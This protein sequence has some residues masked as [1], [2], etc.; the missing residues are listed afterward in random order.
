M[1]KRRRKNKQ[2]RFRFFICLLIALFVIVYAAPVVRDYRGRVGGDM[3]KVEIV[4]G[5]GTADVAQALQ[6]QG[7]IKNT[8]W[9]R[10]FSKICGYDGRYQQGTFSVRQHA[11]YRAAFEA[12]QHADS[13]AVRVTIPEGYELRQIADKL[14]AAGLIDRNKFY[15]AV[16]KGDF[17]Y[18][19]LAGL[20][21]RENR[22]E[23]Y[24]FPD[25]Y[26]FQQGDSEENII[27]IMLQ[28]FNE[29]Y[30]E[31]YRKRAKELSMTDDQV[32]TLASV[33]ER[34]AMGDAD[35]ALVAGVFHNRL[36][37]AQYPY[38]ESCATVQYILKERKAVLS[39]KDTGIDSPYNT[40]R[41]PG[42]PIGPI[43]SPGQASIQAALYPAKTDYLFFVLDSSGTHRFAKTF[44]EHQQ[45]MAK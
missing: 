22:L 23:G 30:T 18:W 21:K 41:Y 28:R 40:Y 1:R 37:N 31:T 8:F 32:I 27:N 33:I 39:T 16:E 5:S 2:V 34:E 38:L 19:F 44:A 24:L 14:Q 36:K 6:N 35:R 15:Q 45:N 12:L 17:D 20:P 10:V 4:A 26:L 29:V 7:V 25:T 43:A 11:G 42:L 9:F 3:V 13:T